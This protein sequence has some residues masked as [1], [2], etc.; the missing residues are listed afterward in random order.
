MNIILS[1]IVKRIHSREYFKKCLHELRNMEYFMKFVLE[2]S[3]LSLLVNSFIRQTT[4]H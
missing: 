3:I 1:T 4:Q 2:G